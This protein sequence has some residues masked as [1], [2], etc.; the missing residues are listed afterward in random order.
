MHTDTLFEALW[1]TGRE[2]PTREVYAVMD[3]ARDERILPLLRA[4]HLPHVCLYEEV[5]QELLEVAPYLVLLRREAPGVRELLER[6]WGHAWGIFLTSSE[7]VSGV[8]RHLRRFLKVRDG[9]GQRLYF[10]YYDPRV[11]RTFLPTCDAS[12]LRRFLGPLHEL[13]LEDETGTQLLGYARASTGA[14]LTQTQD[15][16]GRERPVLEP[17]AAM[18]HRAM[19]ALERHFPQ[20]LQHLGAARARQ[21]LQEGLAAARGHGIEDAAKAVLFALGRT[22]AGAQGPDFDEE[23]WAAK[24]RRAPP[25]LV[26]EAPPADGDARPLTLRPPQLHALGDGALERFRGRMLA[27]LRHVF[28]ER[29]ETLSRPEALGLV[30][31]G[32]ALAGRHAIRDEKSIA[33]LTDLLLV[34][35]EGFEDRPPLQW[36]GALLR[37]ASVPAE[38]KVELILQMLRSQEAEGAH[39]SS[40]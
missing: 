5:P 7:D 34:K 31:A 3:A 37:S 4:S 25:R 11:L 38:S 10:R 23:A 8:R 35:G 9:Q 33:L 30:N 36:S 29:M 2:A 16:S 26:P 17:P 1:L 20:E 13:L 28:P 32:L 18:E 21:G 24:L 27:H 6:A 39:A 12:E 15:V 40:R 14:L 22:L 19:T